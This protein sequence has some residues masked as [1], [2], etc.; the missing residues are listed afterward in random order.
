MSHS[1]VSVDHSNV[2]KAQK[3]VDTVF[4]YQSPAERIS[5]R[6]FALKGRWV[7]R[8]L[9]WVL[10]V[11]LLSFWIAVDG[12]N[13]AV[14][15]SGLY[16]LRKDRT[17]AVWL[18]WYAVHPSAR[19]QGV[20]GALL[21]HA[22]QEARA[23]GA[24]Y[25]RLYTSDSEFIDGSGDAQAVYEKYGLKVKKVKNM[26]GGLIINRKGIK[27]LTARKIIRQMSL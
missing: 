11:D 21:R 6:L 17:E 12:N 18:G 1:I 7:Y 9:S 20:G 13:D 2:S 16:S 8:V 22:I 26:F 10:G 19:G 15:I 25:L 14:G 4:V 24:A 27:L 3:L 23:T 5:L